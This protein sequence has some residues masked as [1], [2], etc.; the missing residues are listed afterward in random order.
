MKSKPR[1][2]IVESLRFSDENRDLFEGKLIS[3]ILALSCS[4]SKYTYLRTK[5]ELEEV[6]DH[7]TAAATAIFISPAT[8]TR[9]GLASR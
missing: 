7:L 1:V 9:T 2:F 4:Q 8:G 3:R 5:K 6:M